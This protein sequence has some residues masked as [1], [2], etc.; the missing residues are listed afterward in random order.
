MLSCGSE[1][2]IFTSI[3]CQA[4]PWVLFSFAP[5][6][7]ASPSLVDLSGR[8]QQNVPICRKVCLPKGKVGPSENEGGDSHQAPDVFFQVSKTGS[9]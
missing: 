9:R 6:S 7:L 4:I 8:S 1:L 5:Y 2:V 3:K